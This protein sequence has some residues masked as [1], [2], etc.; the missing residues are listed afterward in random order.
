MKSTVGAATTLATLGGGTT[1]LTLPLTPVEVV[2][3]SGSGTLSG[4]A[5]LTALSQLNCAVLSSGG[6]DCWG[7]NEDG[8]LGGGSTAIDSG[9]PV[10]V[11]GIGGHGVLAGVVGLVGVGKV[12]STICANLSAGTVDC[13][14]AND[15]GDIGNGTQ[16]ESAT[17]LA[18]EGIGGVGTLGGV[19][20]LGTNGIETVCGDLKSGGTDCWGDNLGDNNILGADVTVGISPPLAVRFP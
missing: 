9:V 12:D 20:N 18:V 8:E 6:V 7:T 17:P 13:W 4:V 16:T 3:T 2:G 19:T 1:E 11:Q 15:Q 10:A 5:S 14:G